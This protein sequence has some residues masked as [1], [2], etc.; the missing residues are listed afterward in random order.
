MHDLRKKALL[1]SRKTTSRKARSKPEDSPRSSLNSSPNGSPGN[2]RAGSRANSRPNSRPGSR[3][4]SEDEGV[5]DEELDDNMTMSTDSASGDDAFEE[6]P[7]NT[8]TDRLNDRIAELQDRKGTSV[9]GREATLKAY[10]HLIRHHYAQEQLDK[11][12]SDVIP[13]LLKIIKGGSSEEERSLAIKALT[14]TIFT[15]PSDSE[16][17]VKQVLS[18]LKVVCKD[19][20]EENIKAEAIQALGILVMYGGGKE[21]EERSE[22]MLDY[23][24]EIIE[25]DGQE[26]NADDSAPVV[27]AALQAWAFVATHLDHLEVQIDRAMEVFMEQ[28]DS[29]DP[30]VQT[31]AGSNI[32]LLLEVAREYEEE[33]GETMDLS[34]HDQYKVMTRMEEIRKTSA[35][36]VSKKARSRLHENFQ[37]IITSLERGVGPY[38][39]TAL[40]MSNPHSGGNRGGEEIR[41]FGYR[42]QLR[43]QSKVMIIDTWILQTR[44]EMFKNLLSGG[45]NVHIEENPV[46]QDALEGEW[47]EFVSSPVARP[48]A[49][50]RGPRQKDT[51][52]AKRRLFA[53]E[54]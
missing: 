32:A 48:R 12:V 49:I 52:A 8:W 11:H 20:E 40:K 19:S 50:E 17:V 7:S 54:L 16:A 45:L 39:S 15:C 23:L 41:E 10:L 29:T 46:M 2:S 30:D 27:T 13:A 6:S 24:L 3:Y 53:Q 44:L 28:L 37:S 9:Q 36:S 5:T 47:E 51:K 21:E 31:S 38:Y 4:A 25:S 35:K 42:K 1:E 43:V 18:T 22:G 33:T 14:V 34:S 26:A